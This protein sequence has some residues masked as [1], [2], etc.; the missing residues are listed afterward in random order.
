MW[1]PQAA[2]AGQHGP[3]PHRAGPGS[4]A[5]GPRQARPS[6]RPLHPPTPPPPT[7]PAPV[8]LRVL[9]PE[10]RPDLE[11]ALH[12]GADRHL[13]VQL[14]RLRQAARLAHVVELEHG[15]AALGGA[16]D[17]LGRVDLLEALGEQHAAEELR[18]RGGWGGVGG[19]GGGRVHARQRRALSWPAL[20]AGRSLARPAAS[21]V[22]P[23]AAWARC[24]C[25][26]RRGAA[27]LA[28]CALQPEDGL[29]GGRAQVHEAVVQPHVLRHRGQHLPGLRGGRHLQAGA[30]EG[31]GG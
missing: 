27:H 26:C 9:R 31:V 19:V 20:R 29:V 18:G 23:P 28:H 1:V 12:V 4:R 3:E 5:A 21:R 10:D 24:S 15:G 16:S 22:P 7:H 17:Q 13:L 6:T 30:G 11:H 14:R 2:W 8:R 25:C